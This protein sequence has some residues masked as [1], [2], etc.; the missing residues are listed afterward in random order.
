MALTNNIIN[1]LRTKEQ[2]TI[3]DFELGVPFKNV[4]LERQGTNGRE[5]YTLQSFFNYLV[6]FLNNTSFIN[7]SDTEPTADNINVWYDTN[8][9]T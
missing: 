8:I 7:Y 4:F 1:F 2:G 9:I 5:F 3:K 6:E